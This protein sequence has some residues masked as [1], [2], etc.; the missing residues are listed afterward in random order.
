MA[1]KIYF[2]LYRAEWIALAEH[3][4][5][6]WDLWQS[7][8][9]RGDSTGPIFLSTPNPDLQKELEEVLK[10]LGIKAARVT[11]GQFKSWIENQYRP[12]TI[13]DQFPE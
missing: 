3:K 12:N 2:K 9:I 7:L 4:T 6:F 13:V 5:E 8:E 10:R 1:T 11:A